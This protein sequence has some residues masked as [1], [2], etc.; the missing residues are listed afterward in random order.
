M[1]TKITNILAI[2]IIGISHSYSQDRLSDVNRDSVRIILKGVLDTLSVKLDTNFVKVL[3]TNYP[4]NILQRIHSQLQEHGYS[5]RPDISFYKGL[6]DAE[7][8]LSS[9]RFIVKSF[10]L[11]RIITLDNGSRWQV[12]KLY[13]YILKTKYSCLYQTVAGCEVNESL[14][15]YVN[16]YDLVSEKVMQTYF[17]ED[18]LQIAWESV[19]STINNSGTQHR[20]DWIEKGK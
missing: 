10:G 15:A 20:N 2:F 1:K 11:D 19:V 7:A 3:Y 5:I 16:A 4:R 12:E 8:D 6:A 18:V 13:A 9:G 14:K 17:K